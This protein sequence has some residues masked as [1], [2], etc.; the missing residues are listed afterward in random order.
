VICNPEPESAGLLALSPP[1]VLTIFPP[2]EAL[3]RFLEVDV[4]GLGELAMPR[5]PLDTLFIDEVMP[6]PGDLPSAKS[7]LGDHGR[8]G[9]ESFIVL[10]TLLCCAVHITVPYGP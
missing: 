7:I 10:A 1:P 5:T 6:D 3:L 4:D 9:A 8:V 2:E